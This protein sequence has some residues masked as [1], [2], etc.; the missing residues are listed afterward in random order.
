VVL[1]PN[2]VSAHTDHYRRAPADLTVN[3]IATD[4][5]VVKAVADLVRAKVG[6]AGK[7]L[8][9][10]GSTMDT[11]SAYSMLGYKLEADGLGT[12]DIS[13]ISLVGKQIAEVAKPFACAL[14]DI[15]PGQ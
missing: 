14:A 2:L 13:Q 12:T 8:V 7:I 3:G 5:R 10:E 6:S 4:W 11:P 9:M 15:C 1:K